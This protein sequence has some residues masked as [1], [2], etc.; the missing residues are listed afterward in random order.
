MNV[1]VSC[2]LDGV[3]NFVTIQN[4]KITLSEESDYIFESPDQAVLIA[5]ELN[6]VYSVQN[7]VKI[8]DIK[9]RPHIII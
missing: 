6:N 9:V 7:K 4:S 5:V 1:I 8:E 3:E 2:I